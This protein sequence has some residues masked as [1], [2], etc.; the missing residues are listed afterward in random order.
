MAV[1]NKTLGQQVADELREL[2]GREYRPG[3]RLPSVEE[4]AARYRVSVVPIREGL[5]A[6]A[7]EGLVVRKRRW[8][9]FVAEPLADDRHV[10]IFCELDNTRPRCSYFFRRVPQALRGFLQA[11]DIPSRAYIGLLT[12]PEDGA[13]PTSACEEFFHDLEGDRF[14]AVIEFNSD[15]RLR[16]RLREA[17]AAK[18]LAHIPPESIHID[19]F[20]ML[21]M[22][23]RRLREVG[24]RRV[25]TL[26]VVSGD[27]PVAASQT[28]EDILAR[29]Y[30]AAGLE[31]HTEWCRGDLDPKLPG[32]GWDMFRE[33]WVARGEKPDGLLV[34]D[35]VLF[36]DVTKAI[37]AMQIAVPERLH[38][39][40]HSNR[41]SG[42]FYPFPVDRLETDPDEYAAL[43]AK[44]LADRMRGEVQ[45]PGATAVLKAR[46][47]PASDSEDGGGGGPSEPQNTA[48]EMGSGRLLSTSIDSDRL[49]SSQAG[50][51]NRQVGGRE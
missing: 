38:V 39:V 46:L 3:D 22:G 21:D 50:G 18:G 34:T 4:L 41:G 20:G 30:R 1:V 10:A 28:R 49:L 15:D 24:C 23:L 26:G 16:P 19:Y 36:G 45:T 11:Q 43:F 17:I 44:I 51:A 27:L 42:L 6:L 8:G 33:M 13:A 7:H 25:A 47:V 5:L 48:T 2:I 32:A 40:T 14:S 9:T 37:L 31:C 35:D 12:E 29:A